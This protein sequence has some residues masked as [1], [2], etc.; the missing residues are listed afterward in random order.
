MHFYGYWRWLAECPGPNLTVN[1]WGIV[2][3]ILMLMSPQYD[4][5]CCLKFLYLI[6]YPIHFRIKR[7]CVL[8]HLF[9]VWFF[10]HL[11]CWWYV[12]ITFLF[13]SFFLCISWMDWKQCTLAYNWR[14]WP[15]LPHIYE[16]GF[17][18]ISW[19]FVTESCFENSVIHSNIYF[20]QELSHLRAVA[21]LMTVLMIVSLLSSIAIVRRIL[22]ATSVLKVAWCLV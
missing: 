1:I 13:F 10:G 18:T 3:K 12:M 20:S 6:R 17:L 14:A 7:S 11:F 8:V 2:F 4:C 5:W 22:M 15:I 19:S 21:V 9:T 16:G